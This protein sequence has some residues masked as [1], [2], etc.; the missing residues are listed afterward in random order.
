MINGTS[1]LDRAIAHLE[2]VLTIV[3]EEKWSIDYTHANAPLTGRT[4]S[5]EMN[6]SEII[7]FS[8]VLKTSAAESVENID[9]VF[10]ILK[11]MTEIL[12]HYSKLAE[13]GGV[14]KE[15]IE[16]KKEELKYYQ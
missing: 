4:L 2:R 15:I 11:M 7:N 9:K 8:S 12:E 6:I 13:I 14:W 3:R 5:N 1:D 10:A 16:H